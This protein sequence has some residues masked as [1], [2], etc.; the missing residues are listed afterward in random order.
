MLD[1]SDTSVVQSARSAVAEDG[2]NRGGDVDREAADRFFE[3]LANSP[4][5]RAKFRDDPQ[6][7]AKQ[8]GVDLDPE[9][10]SGTNW[11]AVPDEELAQRVSKGGG[12]WSG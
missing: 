4:E 8:A 1:A 9:A 6:G 3:Q 5:L 2:H 11:A 7:T 10:L 12:S